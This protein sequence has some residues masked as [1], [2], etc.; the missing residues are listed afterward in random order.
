MLTNIKS[1]LN[2]FILNLFCTNKIIKPFK[3]KTFIIASGPSLNLKDIKK[4]KNSTIIL[5]NNTYQIHKQ[6]DKSNEIYFFTTDMIS[7]DYVI[8][9]LSHDV[10]KIILVDK[11]IVTFKILYFLLKIFCKKNDYLILP[12]YQIR[13]FKSKNYCA[14]RSIENLNF[15][16]IFISEYYR[17]KKIFFELSKNMKITNI[18]PY[19]VLFNALQLVILGQSKNIITMGFD[20]GVFKINQNQYSELVNLE[21]TYN[22]KYDVNNFEL[23]SKKRLH[24]MN[25]WAYEINKELKK[26]GVNWVNFSKKTNIKTIKKI[27]CLT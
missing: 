25:F 1:V 21:K 15:N 13:Y 4:I 2:F 7:L 26:I 27:E 20:G 18:F 19:S 3:E 5:M 11:P 9:C 16:G 10:K 24:R 22:K 6:F 17:P 14:R 12:K 8:D 23:N